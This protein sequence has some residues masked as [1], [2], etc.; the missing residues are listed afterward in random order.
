MSLIIS[1]AEDRV[2]KHLKVKDEEL[3]CMRG[4]NWTLQEQ[5][6]NLNMESHMWRD[7]ARSNEATVNMLCNEL[8][9]ALDGQAVHGHWIGNI[10]DASSCCWGDYHVDFCGDDEYKE[11]KPVAVASIGSCKGCGQGDAVVL[12][13]PCRH[14]CACVSCATTK[15]VC[16]ACGC[17]KTGSIY[18]NFS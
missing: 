5:L 16:P 4:V 15:R 13:L 14:L 18:V 17:A 7:I 6:G 3:K 2:A 10:D 9:H 12:L 11:Q 1:T 8:Q